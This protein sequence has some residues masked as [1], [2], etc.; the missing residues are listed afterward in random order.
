MANY[1][2]AV[3][4]PYTRNFGWNN[5]HFDIFHIAERLHERR[6]PRIPKIKEKII[7]M[8][9]E[10]IEVHEEDV[11]EDY[12]MKEEINKD[13][14]Y[15]QTNTELRILTTRDKKTKMERTI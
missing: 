13:T 12:E 9:N 14:N 2:Y 8:D 15:K 5:H 3:P 4:C 1:D 11:E 6:M 7:R 10:D